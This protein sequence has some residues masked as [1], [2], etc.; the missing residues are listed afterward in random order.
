MKKLLL[1]SSFL[2]IL[3][4]CG[5]KE[6]VMVDEVEMENEEI[7]TEKEEIEKEVPVKKEVVKEEVQKEEVSNLDYSFIKGKLSYPSDFIPK[8]KVC[9][10]S[11]TNN[12]Q[13]CV[14]SIDDSF[15]LK[16]EADNYLVYA[17][18]NDLRKEAPAEK[19]AYYTKCDDDFDESKCNSE[20][21]YNIDFVCFKDKNCKEA[22]TPFIVNLKSKEIK[23][24]KTI[25]QGWYLPCI[26]KE[27]E[28]NSDV[29]N[30]YLN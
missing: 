7:S 13:T 30:N 8:M 9:A 29:W 12:K 5:H 6:E 3:S 25:S 11:L 26:N 4:G 20:N 19:V 10:V 1:V 21:W 18:V 17:S 14:D 16:L 22:F 24:L 2:L 15:N 27:C 28:S 23:E